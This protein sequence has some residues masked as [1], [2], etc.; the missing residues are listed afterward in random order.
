M[1]EINDKTITQ[2]LKTAENSGYFEKLNKLYNTI[3]QGKCH[4]CTSCC[5]ES[6]HT[7]F[8]EF[9]NIWKYLLENRALMERLLPRIIKY[10]FLEMVEKDHCAFLDED[11]NCLIY[12]F[13]PMVCRLFGHWEEHEYEQS[14]KGVLKENLQ[15][16]KYFKNS[17]GLLLPEDVINY[18]IEYCKDFEVRKRIVR[19]QRQTLSDSILTMESGFFMRGLLTE[20]L[21]NTGLASWFVYTTMDMDEA[22]ELRV[23]IM[24]EYLE[25]G[26]SETLDSLLD[27]FR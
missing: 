21:M 7:H 8:V 12:S 16:A 15:N 20:E 10:Y 19:S 17:Y 6:V 2:A 13:R 24:Q 26:Y 9:L 11:N 22:G 1:K 27:K 25:S 23:N 4:G 3:P 5:M 14:Y 18:K